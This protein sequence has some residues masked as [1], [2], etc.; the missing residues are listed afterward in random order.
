MVRAKLFVL[1]AMATLALENTHAAHAEAVDIPNT[2]APSAAAEENNS[3]KGAGMLPRVASIAYRNRD[4][5]PNCGQDIVLKRQLCCE[6]ET[7][8]D[9]CTNYGVVIL[10]VRDKHSVKPCKGCGKP[11]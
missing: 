1:S 10:T 6:C 3:S 4:A 7:E 11:S 5:C 2:C 8:N 9:V